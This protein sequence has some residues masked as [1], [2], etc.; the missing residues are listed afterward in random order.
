MAVYGMFRERS[1]ETFPEWFGPY[2]PAI[3][4]RTNPS[5]ASS[6]VW[7]FTVGIIPP[8]H[9]Y[10]LLP[11]VYLNTKKSSMI[12]GEITVYQRYTRISVYSIIIMETQTEVVICDMQV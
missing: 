7:I 11:Y 10:L 3:A 5:T 12:D 2:E 8:V 6:G 9:L 1:Y 4:R